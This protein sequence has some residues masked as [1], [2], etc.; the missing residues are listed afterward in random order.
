[1]QSGVTRTATIALGLAV[2]I[3]LAIVAVWGLAPRDTPEVPPGLTEVKEPAEIQKRIDLSHLHIVSS[4]NYLGHRIYTVK[5]TLRNIS[6]EPIRLV[7]VKLIFMD[8]DKKVIQEQVHPAF[9]AKHPPI[10][11]G[12]EYRFEIPFENPPRA[13]NYHVPDTVVVRVAY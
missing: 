12:T 5:A 6:N 10:E 13:W 8:Y 2:V 9:E 4:S 3:G 7:D 11:P 1:M